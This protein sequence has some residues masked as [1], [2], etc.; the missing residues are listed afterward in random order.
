MNTSIWGDFQ[1]RISVPL[2]V[3][4]TKKVLKAIL[5]PL[6]NALLIVKEANKV[7]KT[8]FKKNVRLIAKKCKKILIIQS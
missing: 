5:F 3:N 2:R 4:K 1:I 6:K 8:I 7:L